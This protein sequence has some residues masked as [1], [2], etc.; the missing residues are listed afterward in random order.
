MKIRIIDRKIKVLGGDI[1]STCPL[2]SIELEDH[3][4]VKLTLFWGARVIEIAKI[5]KNTILEKKWNNF[6]EEV[7]K[8]WEIERR[9]LHENIQELYD[10]F[11]K[12]KN[13]TFLQHWLKQIKYFCDMLMCKSYRRKDLF[14]FWT[15]DNIECCLIYKRYT[16]KRGEK[17]F[18]QLIE[19][20]YSL[21]FNINKDDMFEYSMKIRETLREVYV[22]MPE[23][24]D[25]HL[26]R[27]NDRSTI[28]IQVSQ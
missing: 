19:Q 26:K 12:I 24:L 2:T 28:E 11:Q 25:Y 4:L 18:D 21:L 23:L 8:K 13:E 17:I 5:S 22:N 16:N 9:E 3:E 10:H 1:D 6:C 15:L 20:G 27:I 14:L 7:K